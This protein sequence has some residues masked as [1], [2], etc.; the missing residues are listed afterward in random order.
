MSTADHRLS[1]T[2]TLQ[3]QLKE[4]TERRKRRGVNCT[5]SS[6]GQEILSDW[7]SAYIVR[8][9]AIASGVGPCLPQAPPHPPIPSVTPVPAASSQ[10]LSSNRAKFS[11]FLSK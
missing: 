9:E 4:L 7:I 3:K 5:V 1:L 2:E 11:N 8:E 6:V 10:P